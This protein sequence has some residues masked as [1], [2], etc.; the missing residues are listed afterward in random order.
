MKI[1]DK[2]NTSKP[3]PEPLEIVHHTISKCLHGLI[4]IKTWSKLTWNPEVEIIGDNDAKVLQ[5]I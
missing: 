3:L 5:H 4:L 2:I 1:C